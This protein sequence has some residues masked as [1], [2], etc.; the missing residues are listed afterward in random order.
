MH[1]FTWWGGGGGGGGGGRLI[2]LLGQ[3]WLHAHR[4]PES[5]DTTSTSPKTVMQC[6][7]KVQ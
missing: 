4:S 3:T 1:C 2:M 6:Q 7:T 5:T